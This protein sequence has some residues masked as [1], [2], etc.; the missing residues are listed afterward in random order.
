MVDASAYDWDPRMLNNLLA[1]DYW[2][3]INPTNDYPRLDATITETQFE[4]VISYR[5]ASF[6]KLRQITLNYD[7]PEKWLKNT[8]ISRIGVYISSKNTAY[9]YSKMMK[10]I[11]PERDGSISWPLAR[12]YTF[13]VNVDF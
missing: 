9:L 2:T 5:D 10:G 4:S 3:P 11:D 7:L 8:P 13:G 1:V 12:F 6:I